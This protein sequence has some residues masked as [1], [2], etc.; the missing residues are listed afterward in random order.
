M[1]NYEKITGGKEFWYHK[2]K[3]IFPKTCMI[4]D[5]LEI[6]LGVVDAVYKCDIDEI[7]SPFYY[8]YETPCLEQITFLGKGNSLAQYAFSLYPN[9]KKIVLPE[10]L[11]EIGHGALHSTPNLK[12]IR[13]PSSVRQIED[14]AFRQYD[15]NSKVL[16]VEKG[17]PAEEVVKSYVAG[18]KDLTCRVVLSEA[19][20][21]RIDE[22]N[23][24]RQIATT[25]NNKLT[26]A[27]QDRLD[28]SQYDALKNSLKAAIDGIYPLYGYNKRMFE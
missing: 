16:I 17:S 20:Q 4:E 13:I 2:G 3:V 23:R 22:E 19:E 15:N 9:L 5:R 25:L 8:S 24:L 21:K 11:K 26:F 10:G 14:G 12:E 7:I 28:A 27:Y 6:P 1:F 18:K